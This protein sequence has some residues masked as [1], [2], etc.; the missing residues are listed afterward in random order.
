M[1]TVTNIDN[2][3]KRLKNYTPKSATIRRS[4]RD[5]LQASM[6]TFVDALEDDIDTVIALTTVFELIGIINRDI[7]TDSLTTSE[8]SSV[9][10]I[11]KSWDMVM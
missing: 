2:T 9:I 3:I 7:N 5:I 1:A 10:D 8:V 6:I 11:L 4:F